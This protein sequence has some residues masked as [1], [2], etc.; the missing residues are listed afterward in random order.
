[1]KGNSLGGSLDHLDTKF[2]RTFL[3]K[4]ISECEEIEIDIPTDYFDKEKVSIELV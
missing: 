4:L 2:N 3:Q 1:M